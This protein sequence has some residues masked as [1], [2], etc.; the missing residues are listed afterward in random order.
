MSVMLRNLM[1]VF[2]GAV[3]ALAIV[4]QPAGAAP[5]PFSLPWFQDIDLTEDQQVLMQQLQDKY[6][7]EI[8]AILYPEQREKFEEAIQDGYSMRRA[9]R[10]M[11][12]TPEQKTELASVVK[13]IPK[14]SI[15]ASLT[16]DQ[17][18][19]VFMKKKEMFMPTAEEIQERIKAG[20]EA[21]QQFAPDA[22]DAE[23]APTAE[24]IGEKIKAGFEKKKAFM[25]SVEDIKEKISEQMEAALEEDD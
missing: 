4:V 12:L 23:L 25:P 17:K 24:E 6:V 19:E 14:S 5:F 10:E 22:P 16:P 11:Y 1:S 2:M 9:F 7:P 3:L 8:E 18:K 13:Q 21:K 20:I 15:F